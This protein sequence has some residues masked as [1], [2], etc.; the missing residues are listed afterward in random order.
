MSKLENI[1]CLRS[2]IQYKYRPSNFPKSTRIHL[3]TAP[4]EVSGIM[5]HHLWW[6]AWLNIPLHR[7]IWTTHPCRLRAVSVPTIKVNWRKE[8]KSI[9][10]LRQRW[11]LARVCYLAWQVSRRYLVS[12]GGQ[13]LWTRQLA[14]RSLWQMEATAIIIMLLPRLSMLRVSVQ[15]TAAVVVKS[16]IMGASL[17]MIGLFRRLA[18]MQWS[19]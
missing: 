11:S 13:A 19:T 18:V 7:Q 9:T 6:K 14:D 4:W 10:V 12:M 16:D 17:W 8:S 5:Q 2:S 15:L 1:S 3:A